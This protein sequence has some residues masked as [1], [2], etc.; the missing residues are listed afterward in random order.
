[1]YPGCYA[2]TCSAWGAQKSYDGRDRGDTSLALT[3]Y[4][5][6][7]YIQLDLGRVRNVSSIRIVGRAS[8]PTCVEQFSSLNVYLSMQQL[9]LDTGSLC[10]GSV[11]FGQPG[12][13]REVECP[14]RMVGRYVTVM[15][16]GAGV[17]ALQEITA[18]PL[19]PQGTRR[20][21][22]THGAGI[23]SASTTQTHRCEMLFVY[24]VVVIR[25]HVLAVFIKQGA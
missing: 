18:L 3:K 21:L 5:Y 20:R 23:A 11:P 22:R 2:D 14:P 25:G 7:P 12:Q 6:Q 19:P 16:T 4:A 8:C 9:G 10:A 13:V 24:V 15:H 17:L 1:M